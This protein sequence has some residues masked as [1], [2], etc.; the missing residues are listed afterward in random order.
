MPRL[1]MTGPATRMNLKLR[2]ATTSRR[3][4]GSTGHNGREPQEDDEPDDA[5]IGDADG[6]QEQIGQSARFRYQ[7][8]L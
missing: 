5:G 3:S 2:K 1:A 6:L 7:E 4:L 8:V